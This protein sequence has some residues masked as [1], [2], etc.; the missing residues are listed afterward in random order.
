MGVALKERPLTFRR[1]QKH[2][3]SELLKELKKE[4]VEALERL[5]EL[6]KTTQDEKIRLNANTAVIEK[7][8]EVAELVN[9]DETTRT[10]GEFKYNKDGPR[11]LEE[12]DTPSIDFS[13][14]QDVE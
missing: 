14:I 4:G 13:N 6:A 3:L 9:K 1:K 2:E 7:L 12:D 10:L 11:E 5:V 8:V